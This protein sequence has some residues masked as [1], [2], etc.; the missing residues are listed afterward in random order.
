M[1]LDLSHIRRADEH[2]EREIPAGE[3]AGE[4]AAYRVH[5]PARLVFDVTK[6]KTVFRLTGTL[7]SELELTCSR[8]LE[9]YRFPVA[10]TFD[11]RYLPQAEPAEEGVER[12][13][14]VEDL[15]ASFYRDETIDL[16]ELVREQFYLA[17]PMKPLC[18][19]G[20]KGLCSQCG[21]NLNSSSCAC[22]AAWEDPRLAPLKTLR[23]RRDNA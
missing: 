4:D 3:L 13:V 5:L 17:L 21:T 1:L 9:P 15:D 8:C 22:T 6:D 18:T 2:V 14:A 10:V 7:A 19:E 11:Q 16:G 20:C 23:D 12:E